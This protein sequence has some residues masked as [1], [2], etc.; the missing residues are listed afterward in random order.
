MASMC[1]DHDEHTV[2]RTRTNTDE[3][4]V[5]QHR[6][7]QLDAEAATESAWPHVEQQRQVL[8][9]AITATQRMR[10]DNNEQNT[11]VCTVWEVRSAQSSVQQW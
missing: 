4:W 9:D 1:G 5:L 8:H 11:G 6:V 10:A 7:A 3:V 2:F